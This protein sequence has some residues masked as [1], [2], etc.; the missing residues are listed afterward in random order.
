MDREN[1]IHIYTPQYISN[2]REWNLIT[3]IKDGIEG[4]HLKQSKSG[5][6]THCIFSLEKTALTSGMQ[7]A[8]HWRWVR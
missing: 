1:V 4:H 2:N 3:C 6:E 5:I 8:G 7:N